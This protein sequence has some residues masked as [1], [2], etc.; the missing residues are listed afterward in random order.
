MTT[1]ETIDA[2]NRILAVLPADSDEHASILDVVISLGKK[3]VSEVSLSVKV[4]DPVVAHTLVAGS[5]VLH[6]FGLPGESNIEDCRFV[7]AKGAG[8][9]IWNR[10]VSNSCKRRF[11]HARVPADYLR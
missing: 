5:G 3:Q 7:L 4:A 1:Q 11:H 2:L 9:G 8:P 10:W 6:P